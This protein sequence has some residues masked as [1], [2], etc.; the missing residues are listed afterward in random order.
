MPY[1]QTAFDISFAIEA[2]MRHLRVFQAFMD[3]GAP[4]RRVR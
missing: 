2:S 4:P 3:Q 1:V